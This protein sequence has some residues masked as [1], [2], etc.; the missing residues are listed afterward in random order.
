MPTLGLMY[1]YCNKEMAYHHFKSL[2]SHGYRVAMVWNG[3][4]VRSC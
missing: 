1:A 2:Q 3:L 4:I